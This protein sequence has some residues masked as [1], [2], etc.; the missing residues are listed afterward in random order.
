MIQC[1]CGKE[2]EKQSSLNSHARF[3]DKYKKKN[4]KSKYKINENLYRCECNKEFEKSQSLNAHFCYCLIHRENKPIIKTNKHL[5]NYR[6]WNK[7]LTKDNNESVK[8]YGLTYSNNIKNNISKPG[9]LN[10][11]HTNEAKE[12][13]SESRQK[14][15]E[16]NESHCKWYL[17]NNGFKDIKVQ[18]TWERD[19]AEILTKN[20][21]KWERIKLKYCKYKN[22]TPDFYLIDY[23]IFIEVKGWWR[24]Y[25]IEKTKKVLNEHNI[26]LRIIEGINEI[27]FIKNNGL[28]IN[29]LIKISD[30]NIFK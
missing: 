29:K 13:I 3:C 14:I 23:N 10:K 2:Y 6:N 17:V 28:D 21:I 9:F 22:Y 27:N 4:N 1:E 24:D 5:D 8:Q 12:K 25:D 11:K 16:S 15:L 18:G 19:I 7:G 30:L 20:N 26:D